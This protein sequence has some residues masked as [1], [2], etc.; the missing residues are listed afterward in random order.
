MPE[1]SSVNGTPVTIYGYD[2]MYMV[3]FSYEGVNYDIETRDIELNQLQE[4]LTNI[5][6]AKAKRHKDSRSKSAVLF[7]C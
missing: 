7:L 2:N 4:L 6:C 3:N 1:V 5:K